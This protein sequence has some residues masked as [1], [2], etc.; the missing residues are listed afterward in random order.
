M[1]TANQVR[2]GSTS[3]REQG[4]LRHLSTSTVRVSSC[5]SLGAQLIN[6]ATFPPSD[7]PVVDSLGTDSLPAGNS[8][9]N[10]PHP[11]HSY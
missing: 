11:N 6:Y 8:E 4:I 3:L 10:V 5:E 1:G 9:S 2:N 7:C